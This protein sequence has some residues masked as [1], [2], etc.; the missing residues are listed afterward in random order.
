MRNPR[1]VVLA[2]AL[3]TGAFVTGCGYAPG[4][5]PSAARSSCA[6]TPVEGAIRSA[7]AGTGDEEWALRI[8]NRESHCNPGARNRSGAVGLFQLVNH[9]DLLWAACPY[10]MQAGVKADCNARAARLLYNGSG[11]SAWGG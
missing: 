9:N 11:R 3:A 4:P 1:H 5:A 8:A 2:L 10:D 6:G 7:F